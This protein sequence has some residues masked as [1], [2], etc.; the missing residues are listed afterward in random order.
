[1]ASKNGC[2]IKRVARKKILAKMG[3]KT[4][5]EMQKSAGLVMYGDS[6]KHIESEG[7]VMFKIGESVRFK[8]G[9]RVK[10]KIRRR[11]RFKIRGRTR[12]KICGRVRFKIRGTM[13]DG[14]EEKIVSV[15]D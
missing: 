13:E 8:M 12:F 2:L 7:R 11:L 3:T 5:Y 1:M 6:K 10:F 4:R 9:G 15:R 14:K